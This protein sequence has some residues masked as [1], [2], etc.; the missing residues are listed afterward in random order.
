V[1]RKG[2]GWRQE[3]RLVVGRLLADLVGLG[4]RVFVA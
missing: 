1:S 2:R 3:L 4:L